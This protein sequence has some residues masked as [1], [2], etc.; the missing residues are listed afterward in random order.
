[1]NSQAACKTVMHS[2]LALGAVRML[3]AL[4]HPV[5][6]EFPRL[7]IRVAIIRFDGFR[8]RQPEEPGR[9]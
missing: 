5:Q 7:V 3:K 4:L 6:S 1:M 9:A 8:G 2:S